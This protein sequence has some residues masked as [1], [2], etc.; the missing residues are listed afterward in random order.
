MLHSTYISSGYILYTHQD[1]VSSCVQCTCG[2]RSTD[3]N[4]VG[5]RLP[6]LSRF[7]FSWA[8]VLMIKK[9]KGRVEMNSPQHPL[10][11][12]LEGPLWFVVEK[13]LKVNLYELRPLFVVCRQQT[14]QRGARGNCEDLD[15]KQHILKGWKFHCITHFPYFQAGNPFI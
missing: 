9:K 13:T 15:A 4:A 12:R 8:T 5:M 3:G 1:N 14:Q 6:F 10:N 2:N 11:G 7:M